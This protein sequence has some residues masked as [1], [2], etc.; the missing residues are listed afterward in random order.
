MSTRQESRYL[1]TACL[2][3]TKVRR[4]TSS[5]LQVRGDDVM[6]K[7]CQLVAGSSRFDVPI[8]RVLP[9]RRLRACVR[10]LR[11]TQQSLDKPALS[12]VYFHS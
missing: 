4:C 1:K 10:A 9:V 5:P 11:A 8:A 6:A 2:Y 3:P 12:P 7:C